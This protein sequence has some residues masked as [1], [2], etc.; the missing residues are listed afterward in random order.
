VAL[1]NAEKQRRWR[2][3]RNRLA[4]QAITE[5]DSDREIVAK[6]VAAVGTERAR[7]LAKTLTTATARKKKR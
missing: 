4:A 1:T 7:A 3:K 2:E 6:I 5:N